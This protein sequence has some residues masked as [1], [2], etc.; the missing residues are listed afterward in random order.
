MF[1]LT[2]AWRPRC[3]CHKD[4]AASPSADVVSILYRAALPCWAQRFWG[5][6]TALESLPPQQEGVLWGSLIALV[7]SGR[8]R[9]SSRAAAADGGAGWGKHNHRCL[10]G[11]SDPQKDQR[12]RPIRDP[13]SRED[14]TL[15]SLHEGRMSLSTSASHSGMGSHAWPLRACHQGLCMVC[16]PL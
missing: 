8:P 3:G 14:H 9:S 12:P 13:C 16:G 2:A 1:L 11:P 7:E 5:I 4:Q 15:P 10:V 6:I